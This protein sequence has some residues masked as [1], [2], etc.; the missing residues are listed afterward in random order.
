[1]E[2]LTARADELI[3]RWREA[4]GDPT[5]LPAARAAELAR[6]FGASEFVAEAS[7]RDPGLIADLAA[8]GELDRARSSGDGA[9]KNNP[10]TLV[11]L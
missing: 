10:L 5:R 3:R 4:G 1:M 8:S 11:K 6:V 7:V 2:G 9:A